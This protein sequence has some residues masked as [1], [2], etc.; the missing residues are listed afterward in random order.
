MKKYLFSGIIPVCIKLGS[1]YSMN[2][3]HKLSNLTYQMILSF[4][5]R[6]KKVL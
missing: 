1:R 3:L 2:T 5:F 6:N 4:K